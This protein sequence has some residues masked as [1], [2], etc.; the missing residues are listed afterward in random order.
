MKSRTLLIVLIAV[1]VSIH[2]Q[3][4]G[5]RD[6]PGFVERYLGAP[7]RSGGLVSGGASAASISSI[8]LGIWM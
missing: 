6:E 7:D 1:A 2:A 3:Q 4:P 8:S 5:E